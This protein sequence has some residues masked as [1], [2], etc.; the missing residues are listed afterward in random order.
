LSLSDRIKAI[1]LDL[2]LNGLHPEILSD[3]DDSQ[4]REKQLSKYQEETPQDILFKTATALYFVEY[5]AQL[6]PIEN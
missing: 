3:A 6:I 5:S 4:W 1:I 2:T